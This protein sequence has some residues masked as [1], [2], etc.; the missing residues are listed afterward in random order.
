MQNLTDI[1]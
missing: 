1:A